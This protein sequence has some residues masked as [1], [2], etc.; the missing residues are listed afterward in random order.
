MYE[1]VDIDREWFYE[2]SNIL[3]P[4]ISRNGHV[5]FTHGLHNTTQVRSIG[6]NAVIIARSNVHGGLDKKEEVGYGVTT[7][8]DV[9]DHIWLYKAHDK[10][11]QRGKYMHE[12]VVKRVPRR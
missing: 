7:S 12:F 5:R 6:T 8:I 4:C 2:K 11:H 10:N 1:S 3:D 9:N